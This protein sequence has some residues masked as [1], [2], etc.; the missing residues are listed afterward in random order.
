MAYDEIELDYDLADQMARTFQ[1]GAEQLQHTMQE[2]QGIAST[3][4]EGALLGRGGT[5]F[6]EAIR[7]KLCP[8][9][10]RLTD[11]FKELEGDVQAAVAAM[12][13]ADEESRKQFG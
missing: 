6:V 4:E 9:L 12:R 13:K 8:S 10:G 7:S 5:A 2:M 11:K 3:L 1:Q